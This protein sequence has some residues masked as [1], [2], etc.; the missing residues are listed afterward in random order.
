[1]PPPRTATCRAYLQGG[2]GVEVQAPPNAVAHGDSGAQA[3]LGAAEDAARSLERFCDLR[4]AAYLTGADE[5]VQR[6]DDCERRAWQNFAARIRTA[7]GEDCVVA[8]LPADIEGATLEQLLDALD[9]HRPAWVALAACRG[10][11]PS[12]F[13]CDRGALPTEAL[14]ICASCEVKLECLDHALELGPTRARG[15]WGSTT[16]KAR[17]KAHRNGWD[18]ARLLKEMEAPVPR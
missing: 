15:V 6:L 3:L 12:T 10:R 4:N 5:A 9:L 7:A 17:R 13:V 8:A 1:M 16:G 18:A 2:L 11:D 14:A